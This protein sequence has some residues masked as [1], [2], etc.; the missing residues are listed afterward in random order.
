MWIFPPFDGKAPFKW[1]TNTRLRLGSRSIPR[2]GIIALAFFG[3][4]SCLAIPSPEVKSAQTEA[5]REATLE[6]FVV[7]VDGAYTRSDGQPF[8]IAPGCHIVKTKADSLLEA[9][10]GITVMWKQVPVVYFRIDA[11]TGYRYRVERSVE[12]LEGRY[13]VLKVVLRT[14]DA[15]GNLR[16]QQKIAWG[17]ER[18]QQR[19]VCPN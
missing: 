7:E 1:V 6:G 10:Y 8:N 17:V 12:L 16:S 5:S 14:F 2:L 4:T 18:N 15:D 11:V 9:K 13:N 19:P 3:S